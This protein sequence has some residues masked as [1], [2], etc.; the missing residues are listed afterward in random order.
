M[1]D[2]TSEYLGDLRVEAAHLKSGV[3]IITDAPVDNHGKGEAFSPT[4]LLSTSLACCMTTLMGI[5]AQKHHLDITGLRTEISKIM[6][7][8][9][10]RV[11]E[12]VIH[13]SIDKDLPQEH[14]EGL[15]H[16]AITCPVALS[17]SDSVK[18]TVTF[19]F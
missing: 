5:Y 8:S 2:F 15:K 4:D 14:I 16:A 12:I 11:A 6:G 17:L 18:Q 9:P 7:A 3:K 10:R 13:F 1:A 19:S